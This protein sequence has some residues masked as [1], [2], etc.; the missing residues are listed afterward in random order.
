MK[1]KAILQGKEIIGYWNGREYPSKLGSDYI[2]FLYLI[3]LKKL[4]PE[5]DER[6]F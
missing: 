4:L 5:C 3:F 2:I 6:S 1:V